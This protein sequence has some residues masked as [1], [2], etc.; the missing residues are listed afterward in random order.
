MKKNFFKNTCLVL[1]TVFS[2]S[3][4]LTSCSFFDTG[5]GTQIS[6]VETKY[7]EKTGNTIITISFTNDDMTPVSFTI[8]QGIAGKDGVSIK[9]VSSILSSDGTSVILTISYSDPNVENTVISVPVLQGKG[10]KEVLVDKDE[11]GNTTIQFVYTDNST[12]SKITIPNGKD[13][14]GIENFEVS[15]PNDNGEI[16]IT[17]SFTDGNSKTFKIKNGVSVSNITYNE[18][19]SDDT[20]YVL[21]ISYTDGYSED[22]S[23]DRPKSNRWY[24]GTTSPENDSTASSKAAEGDFYLNKV[25]GYVYLKTSNG[26]WSFLFGMKAD[27]SSSEKKVYHTVYFDPG[28]G[29]IKGTSNIMMASVSNGKTM[30]LSQI[31]TPSYEGYTFLG[32]YTD[33]S[34]VNSGKFTDLTPVYS[35]LQL[36]AKYEKIQG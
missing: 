15:D 25:N 16:T 27:D 11:N 9:N 3:M 1:L 22:V 21:T 26:T 5:N 34:N 13:G 20:H 24:T 32:W 28:E 8:P 36:Y 2:L 18:E 19:K 4:P 7:D 29:K 12:S 14:N 23:L 35:D 31:P 6:N 30:E 10:I 17:V 33:L